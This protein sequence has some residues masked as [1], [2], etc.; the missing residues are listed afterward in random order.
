MYTPCELPY[1]Y[2]HC[3]IPHTPPT[4]IRSPIHLD[5]IFGHAY[6]FLN[7]LDSHTSISFMWSHIHLSLSPSS[8]PTYL[9]L[10]QPV[11]H[12]PISV[13]WIYKQLYKPFET[14]YTSLRHLS[15]HTHIS[16]ISS[17][18]HLSQPYEPTYTSIWHPAPHAPLSI[19]LIM[20]APLST[21]KACMHL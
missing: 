21:I 18:K 19:M 3:P 11:H 2:V 4:V 12:T 10:G 14:S 6:T 17:H 7:Y 8:E 5:W 1:A 20:H 15:P 9:S 13:I 16:V